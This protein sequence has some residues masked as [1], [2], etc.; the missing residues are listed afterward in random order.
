MKHKMHIWHYAF[1]SNSNRVDR[2]FGRYFILWV[3]IVSERL[4]EAENRKFRHTDFIPLNAGR[5]R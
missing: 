5:E 4:Q 1:S 3:L 2:I